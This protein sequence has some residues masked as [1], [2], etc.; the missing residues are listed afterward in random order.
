MVVLREKPGGAVLK[1]AAASDR[2]LQ[3]TGRAVVFDLVADMAARIDDPDLDVT[4]DDVLVLRNTGPKGAPGMPEAGYLPIPKK[5]GRQGGEGHGAHLRRPHERHRLWHHRAAHHAGIVAVG[6]PLALVESGDM[7]R[8][9]VEG[10]R[11]DL[12]VAEDELA[13]RRAILADVPERPLPERGYAR[14]FQQTV[15]QADEGCDFDFMVPR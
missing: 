1:Q 12:L 5:L 3:H 8:L 15:L 14:L 9:D 6:G 7:I 11:I 13:R 4:A 10:R 2:L